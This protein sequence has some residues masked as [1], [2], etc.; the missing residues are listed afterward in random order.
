MLASCDEPGVVA[1]DPEGV[2][3]EFGAAGVEGRGFWEEH[4]TVVGD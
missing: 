1:C 2:G 3:G 4:L